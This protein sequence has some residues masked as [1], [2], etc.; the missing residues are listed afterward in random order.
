VDPVIN[1]P[2]LDHLCF[3]WV[4]ILIFHICVCAICVFAICDLEF[5]ECSNIAAKCKSDLPMH[6][7]YTYLRKMKVF[8]YHHLILLLVW[9]MSYNTDTMCQSDISHGSTILLFIDSNYF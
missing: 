6:G 1:I 4:K 9:H 3:R 5:P 2:T 8:T 7:I